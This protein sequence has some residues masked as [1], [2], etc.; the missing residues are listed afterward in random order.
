MLLCAIGRD[1]LIMC[2]LSGFNFLYD[3]RLSSMMF[4]ISLSGDFDGRVAF[5]DS[6]VSS[7]FSVVFNEVLD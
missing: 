6:L 5:F 1:R 2:G 3:S 4:A 7:I